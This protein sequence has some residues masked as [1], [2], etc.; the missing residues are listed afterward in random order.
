V[1]HVS[2]ACLARVSD[3][4]PP[5][6]SAW[7]RAGQALYR[8]P[9]SLSRRFV[10]MLGALSGSS[11][12][13]RSTDPCRAQKATDDSGQMRV[14]LQMPSTPPRA[15]TGKNQWAAMD[16]NHLYLR[17][18]SP[19]SAVQPLAPLGISVQA[20]ASSDE[21]ARAMTESHR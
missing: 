13:L 10:P 15:S 12:L 1:R 4:W 11:R 18:N 6:E 19:P 21:I 7:S 14:G 20:G 16:T 17:G 5:T 2:I 8:R 9:S 3:R